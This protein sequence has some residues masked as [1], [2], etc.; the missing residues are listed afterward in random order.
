MTDDTT[1]KTVEPE[2]NERGWRM[3]TLGELGPNMPMGIEAGGEFVKGFD[4][5]PW[6]M[7]E[8]RAL[9]K[10]LEENKAE[11]VGNFIAHLL[12]T[13]MTQVGPFSWGPNT[14]DA[15][16][17]L[18]I[19]QMYTGDVLYLYAYTRQLALGNLLPATLQCPL[20]ETQNKRELDL[21]GLDVR[22]MTD[23]AKL[24]QPCELQD[25]L[26]INGELRKLLKIRP[27]LWQTAMSASNA[28]GS[29]FERS[30][31]LIKD[32][33]CG[34]EGIEDGT[35]FVIMDSDIDE[36]SKLDSLLI[37]EAI[38]GTAGP[39]FITELK[40]SRCKRVTKQEID[41]RYQSFFTVSSE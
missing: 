39:Q 30:I 18:A 25:G 14:S 40:C 29:S 3:T 34:A 27:P 16:K 15:E 13:L 36:L 17:T 6:K 28:E 10:W 9:G 23:P 19:S 24:I 20:C 41:Y 12:G 26:V 2:E 7:R 4:S 22:V 33:V 5:R 11:S 35:P 37:E 32:C 38:E 8:E 1:D 21:D 31:A